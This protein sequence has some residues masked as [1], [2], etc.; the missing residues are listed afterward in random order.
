MELKRKAEQK[1]AAIREQLLSQLE[2][3]TQQYAKD[4]ESQL[5]ELCAKLQERE[6]QIY[7][8]E[9]K[10]KNLE[11]SPQPEMPVVSR[12][13]GNVAAS[14]EQEAADSQDCTQKAW[15]EATCCKEG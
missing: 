12:S 3:K 15:K 10:L 8:L 1:I 6:K 2:E 7:I 13:M 14:P 11:S 9:G 4:T 5:N